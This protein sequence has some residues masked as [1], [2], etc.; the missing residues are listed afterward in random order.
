VG[1]SREMKLVLA[2]ELPFI[3]AV[4]AVIIRS[5]GGIR[6]SAILSHQMESGS[7]IA[8]ASGALAFLAALFCMQAKL[9]L[10]PFDAA[11]AEQEIMGGTLIEY[12][13]FP[14]AVFKLTKALMLYI[15]PLFLIIL[16]LGKDLSPYF[17]V[18]KFIGILL[19]IILLKNTNPRLRIDQSIRFFWRMPLIFSLS[20]VILASM[21]F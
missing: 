20:A 10:V 5:H 1:A 16:F 7:N 18:A 19:F 4:V 11:E 2:Y 14:L 12:S 21:G 8:S 13:G 15:M 9:G 6:L 17:L 3:L